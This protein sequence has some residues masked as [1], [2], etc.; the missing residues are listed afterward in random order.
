MAQPKL[1]WDDLLIQSADPTELAECLEPWSFL[2]QGE[3]APIFLNRFGSWFLRR[4][5]GTIAMLDVLDGSVEQVATN[6][7]EFSA[8][9][10]TSEWQEQFLLSF[11][12]FHL[13]EAG[14]VATG[15]QCYA[16]PHP[17]IGGP[18]PTLGAPPNPK[19]TM[20]ADLK[21]WQSICRQSLGGPP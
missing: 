21:V 12:V 17:G 16:I 14:I 1:T 20:L 3:V 8:L 7:D 9:V 4:R 19:F 6:F 15:S 13:H 11:A 18:N 5:D 2:V 10:N